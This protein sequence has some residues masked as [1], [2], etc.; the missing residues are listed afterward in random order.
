MDSSRKGVIYLSFGS[1]IRFSDLPQK[2]M[3]IFFNVLGTLPYDILIKWNGEEFPNK[4]ANVRLEKWL[5]QNDMLRKLHASGQHLSIMP[6]LQRKEGKYNFLKIS[7]SHHSQSLEITMAYSKSYLEFRTRGAFTSPL[8]S[9][10][11]NK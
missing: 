1:K 7:I 9:H 5:P 3:E 4:P 11:L 8:Y 2:T 6:R 10:E